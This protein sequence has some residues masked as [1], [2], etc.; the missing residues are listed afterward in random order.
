[1]K[2]KAIDISVFLTLIICIIATVSFEKKDG[3]TIFFANFQGKDPNKEKVEIN[4]R[5][6]C[7][8]PS[9]TGIGFITVQG[10]K[11]NKAATTWA[12]P[13]AFQDGM[14]GPHWS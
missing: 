7:F 11:I 14:I 6:R 10:F 2:L 1:M 4:V 5:R 8:F 3:K 13:A 12:P 9:K